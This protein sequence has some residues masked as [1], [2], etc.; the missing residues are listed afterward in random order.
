MILLDIAAPIFLML[1]LKTS[2][3]ESASLLG[4]FEIVA[5]S[6]IALVLFSEKVSKRLWIAIS[7]ITVSSVVLSLESSQSLSFS[8]GSFLILA[9]CFC[10]G[11]ENNCTRKISSKSTAQIVTLKV[12]FPGWDLW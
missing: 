7:L 3:A 9:A 10:W 1:G 5:T 2:S 4:N 6:V 12:F 11:L 8:G